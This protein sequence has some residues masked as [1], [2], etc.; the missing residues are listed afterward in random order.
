MNVIELN[1]KFIEFYNATVLSDAKI[2]SVEILDILEEKGL[3]PYEKVKGKN[4]VYEQ[5][6]EDYF[7]TFNLKPNPNKD[8]VEIMRVLVLDTLKY[9]N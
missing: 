4:G 5:S 8:G 1:Q 3:E 2:K 9:E 7:A 6:F